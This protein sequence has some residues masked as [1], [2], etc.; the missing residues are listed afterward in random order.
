M[1]F[2]PIS[3]IGIVGLAFGTLG[4]IASTVETLSKKQRAFK[5]CQARIVWYFE[6][7]E[8]CYLEF[9]NWK[10]VWCAGPRGRAFSDQTY[11]DFFGEHGFV[12]LKMRFNGVLEDINNIIEILEQGPVDVKESDRPP[13]QDWEGLR[14]ILQTAKTDK[15]AAERCIIPSKWYK[16]CFALTKSAKF[17]EI[18]TRLNGRVTEL[19]RFS[20]LKFRMVQGQEDVGRKVSNREL[21]DL[22]SM[23][24]KLRNLTQFLDD[25]YSEHLNSNPRR[26]WT[27]VMGQPNLE[28]AL[29]VFNDDGAFGV[30]FILGR[31][32][33]EGSGSPYISRVDNRRLRE[34]TISELVQECNDG[35]NS[36][37][38]LTLLPSWGTRT[39]MK[40]ILRKDLES[41][42]STLKAREYVRVTTALDMVNSIGLFY[43][44]P[45]MI[46]LCS[47][48]VSYTQVV[49][50]D[51]TSICS[52]YR[53]RDHN[54]H[55]LRTTHGQFFFLGVALL[56]LVL[57][58]PI[59]ARSDARRRP[60][61][62]LS[63]MGYMDIDVVLD[64]VSSKKCK[65]AIEYCFELDERIPQRFLQPEELALCLK[66]LV[67]P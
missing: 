34:V 6:Q 21:R 8:T 53:S 28:K 30:E 27:L 50:E 56:E 55:D 63:S 26:V 18:I 60:S 3:T 66:Y 29:R 7:F 48:G 46:D 9:Q 59:V 5:E 14:N 44:T 57:A 33:S 61:F 12:R 35:P 41:G 39:P 64:M 58:T 51:S 10:D 49:K 1:V 32:E 11:E 62:S 67:K 37:N 19:E 22:G 38:E 20:R 25:L 54:C 15:A 36:S 65:Q 42:I 16:F 43:A 31:L 52:T 24:H 13:A 23:Y 47:C 45:W 2:D 4:F 40:D 17:D